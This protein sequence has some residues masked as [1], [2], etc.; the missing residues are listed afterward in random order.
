MQVESFHP[1]SSI[2]ASQSANPS[3][4]SS[5]APGEGWGGDRS[6]IDLRKSP[7]PHPPPDVPGEESGGSS[8]CGGNCAPANRAFTLVELLVVIG[9]IVILMSLLL[10]AVSRANKEAVRVQCLSNLRQ[11]AMAAQHYASTNHGLF[12]ASHY[13]ITSGS[14][15]INYDWDWIYVLGRTATPGL[16]WLGEHDTPVLK[17]PAWEGKQYSNPGGLYSGYNYNVSFVGGEPQLGQ[18]GHPGSIQCLPVHAGSVN[19]P[20]TTALFADAEN[21]VF[22]CNNLMRS[23][24]PSPSEIQW[25]GTQTLPGG[26]WAAYDDTGGGGAARCAGA[27]GF[28]HLGGCNVAYCDGHAETVYA[29]V[30]APNMT[31]GVGF[32]SQDNKAYGER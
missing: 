24:L 27:Q 16:L 7:L 29:I 19:H 13:V 17:C 1:S 22:F 10:P 30:P 14:T 2:W 25:L 11:M 18:L 6:F 20:S 12:P 4:P 26:T 28:R 9:I 5:G 23:P 32:L 8:W 15:Q 3:S 31:K 21:S